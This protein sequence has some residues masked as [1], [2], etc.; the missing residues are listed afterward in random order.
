MSVLPVWQILFCFCLSDEDRG[1][2]YFTF[3]RSKEILWL[4]VGRRCVGK[5][6]VLEKGGVLVFFPKFL[7]GRKVANIRRELAFKV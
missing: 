4:D 6:V 3:Y 5:Y 2:T 7:H 1:L